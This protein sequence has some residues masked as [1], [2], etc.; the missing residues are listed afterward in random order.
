MGAGV[1]KMSLSFFDLESSL[2]T[3]FNDASGDDRKFSDSFSAAIK[4]Y[5]ESGV[6]VTADAGSVSAG[7]FTGKGEGGMT[8][9]ASDCADIVYAGARA[10]SGTGG[11]DILAARMAEG[12]DAMIAN[13]KVRTDVSGVCAPPSG[14]SFPLSGAAEGS[15]A[16]SPAPME[17]AF[18]SAFEAMNSMSEGNNDY[19]AS[20][21]AMAID[22]YLTRAVANTKGKSA[23]SGSIGVGKMS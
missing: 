10:M 8:V 23:L 22:A 17:A 13:G 21:C 5:V 1:Q 18:F 14:S 9:T 2:K 3:V 12:I 6:I 15:M 20:Q 7:V 19:M 11:N 4:D 16:G